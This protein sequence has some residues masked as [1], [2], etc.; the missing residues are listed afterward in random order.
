M[1]HT[2]VCFC[3]SMFL[4]MDCSPSKVTFGNAERWLPPDFDP[5][6]GV[7]MIERV[8]FPKT[9]QRKIEEYMKEKYPYAYEFIDNFSTAMKQEKYADSAKY[10][11]FMV[12]SYSSTQL[13]RTIN[14]SNNTYHSN[15]VGAFDY[16][17]YDRLKGKRY[18]ST[19]KASSLASM[20]FKGII[21]TILKK[22]E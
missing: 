5:R 3:M 10:S 14:T 19:G 6:T 9:Q 11:F 2:L 13:N 20:T 8:Y 4:F 16:S 17:F 15:T 1:K 21:N 7:L 18:P 12:D 22:F